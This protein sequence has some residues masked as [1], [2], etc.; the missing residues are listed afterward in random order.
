MIMN[1]LVETFDKGDDVFGRMAWTLRR[2]QISSKPTYLD[3]WHE[4]RDI[5]RLA[6]NNVTLNDVLT[7][8]EMLYSLTK[9][10][11]K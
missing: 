7:Q 11:Q 5:L 4:F 6:E 2:E 1:E 10:E 8:A 9:D 3:R